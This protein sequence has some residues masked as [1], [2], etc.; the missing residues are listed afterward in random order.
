VRALSDDSKATGTVASIPGAIDTDKGT[1]Q[2]VIDTTAPPSTWRPGG[3]A[4]ARL[5]LKESA[6]DVVLPRDKVLYEENRP[7]CWL[8]ETRDGK[9]VARRAWVDLG[10]GDETRLIITKGVQPGDQV[11]VEG[12]LGVSDGVRIEIKKDEAKTKTA[13]A[14]PAE[15]VSRP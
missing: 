12:L 2:V 15:A 13:E 9:L 4:T 6:G 14:K 7:Y 3:F 8:A 10:A 1:G 11:I 5:V